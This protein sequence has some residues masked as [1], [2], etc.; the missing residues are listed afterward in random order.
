MRP[1]RELSVKEFSKK[2]IDIKFSNTP[3]NSD[4][5]KVKIISLL[6]LEVIEKGPTIVN[7]MRKNKKIWHFSVRN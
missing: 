4:C 6:I 2:I 5:C 3:L 1:E 7:T